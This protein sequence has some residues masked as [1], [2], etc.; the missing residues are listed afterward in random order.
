MGQKDKQKQLIWCA[1]QTTNIKTGVRS[2]IRRLIE[3]RFEKTG[4]AGTFSIGVNA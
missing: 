4:I 2:F 1:L 3:I